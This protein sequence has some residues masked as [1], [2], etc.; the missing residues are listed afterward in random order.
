[1]E[2]DDFWS[3]HGL[4]QETSPSIDNPTKDP[5]SFSD[6]V[7]M[8]DTQFARLQTAI[9][10]FHAPPENPNLPLMPPSSL[11]LI[12]THHHHK[13]G[14]KRLREAQQPPEHGLKELSTEEVLRLASARFIQ[15]SVPKTEGHPFGFV[16]SSLTHAESRN[17]EL[18]EL[19]LS[20]AEKVGNQQ[21]S[22]TSGNPVERVVHY[23][24][25]ALRSRIEREEGRGKGKGVPAGEALEA[26]MSPHPL[27]VTIARVLPFC[28]VIQFTAMHAIIDGIGDAR[29]VHAIDLGIQTGV[30]WA[31]LMDH[32][33]SR[34]NPPCER[35]VI[36]AVTKSET[37]V[38]GTRRFSHKVARQL[39]GVIEPTILLQLDCRLGHGQPE[40]QHVH[41]S[42]QHGGGVLV[43]DAVQANSEA[44]GAGESTKGAK[45][46]KP[47]SDGG[48]R[49]G[50]E[51]ELDVVRGEVRGGSILLQCIL[52]R[53]GGVHRREDGDRH[54]MESEFFGEGIRSVVT[55]EGEER[56]VRKVRIGV[57]RSFFGRSGVEEVGLNRWAEYQAGLIVGGFGSRGRDC[58]IE[59]DG[60]ALIVGWKG[61]PLTSISAWKFH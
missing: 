53:F 31:I 24:A 42:R 4:Y 47:P 59:M 43:Y 9:Q 19:L 32:L 57:W 34:R 46:T 35:L 41:R 26:M 61:T 6:F 52:R 37:V 36:S 14:S 50:G 23:F 11:E 25:R 39:R 5:H 51:P 54:R 30:Q 45:D 16:L 15:S 40:K 33:A 10:S 1:M 18:A 22:P 55:T 27:L 3:S 13:P 17:V 38:S 8:D 28:K 58:T 60:K 48:S 49:A 2:P 29:R 44:R 7:A 56:I 20:A 21:S 12:R